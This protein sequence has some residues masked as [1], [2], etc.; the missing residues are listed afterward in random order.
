MN[1]TP[2]QIKE[3]AATIAG[4]AQAIADGTATGVLYAHVRRLE[5]NVQ[6]L[7]A[8]IGDDRK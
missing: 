4:Q 1:A 8:W 3:L 2:E 5:D 7:K 6:T